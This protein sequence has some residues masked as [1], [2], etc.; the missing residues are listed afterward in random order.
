MSNTILFL[1]VYK[2][3]IFETKVFLNLFPLK[4]KYTF[5][6]AGVLHKFRFSN[7]VSTGVT[8]L[9]ATAPDRP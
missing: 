3:F 4:K 7:K 6:L 9:K 5:N 2:Y 8:N 1:C